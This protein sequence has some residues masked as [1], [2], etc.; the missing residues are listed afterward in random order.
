MRTWMK[1]AFASAFNQTSETVPTW[2]RRI[3]SAR[4]ASASPCRVANAGATLSALG[5]QARPLP[6]RQP[7]LKAPTDSPMKGYSAPHLSVVAEAQVCGG[8]VAEQPRVVGKRL[9]RAV[10]QAER[11][12]V[13]SLLA[14]R[15]RVSGPRAGRSP[16]PMVQCT[17]CASVP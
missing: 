13:P 2:P 6:A 14:P 16:Q 10:V 15:R 1:Q 7:E 9:Q 4:V 17:R 12:L 11:V 3:C 5:A 8:A